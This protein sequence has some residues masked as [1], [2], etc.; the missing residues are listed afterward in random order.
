MYKKGQKV[1][2]LDVDREKIYQGTIQAYYDFLADDY[3]GVKHKREYVYCVKLKIGQYRDVKPVY[4]SQGEK[5]LKKLQ[6]IAESMF[7]DKFQI[8]AKLAEIYK[9]K[10]VEIVK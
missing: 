6:S 10:K 5:G 7:F 1:W 8:H 9:D 3:Y 4:V 2:F